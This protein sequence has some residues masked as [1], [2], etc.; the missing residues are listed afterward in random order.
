MGAATFDI[1]E[2]YAVNG[3]FTGDY[4]MGDLLHG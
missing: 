3:N 1:I 4:Y 2:D